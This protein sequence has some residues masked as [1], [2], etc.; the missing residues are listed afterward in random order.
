MVQWTTRLAAVRWPWVRI[1]GSA[2]PKWGHP[3]WMNSPQEAPLKFVDEQ[4][5]GIAVELALRNPQKKK[6]KKKLK[7]IKKSG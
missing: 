7:K 3:T 2:P 4:T 5:H 1:P 6:K